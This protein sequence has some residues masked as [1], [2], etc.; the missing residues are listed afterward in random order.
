MLRRNEED[1]EL[2]R[3]QPQTPVATNQRKRDKEGK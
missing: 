2:E 3:Q 1:L